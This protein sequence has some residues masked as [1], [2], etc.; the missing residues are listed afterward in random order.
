[1]ERIDAD[2]SLFDVALEN[3]ERERQLLG[4]LSGASEEWEQILK[5]PWREIRAILLA[6]SDEGQRLRSSHPF[7]GIV[8]EDERREIIARHPPPP[9]LKPISRE[10]PDPELIGR[11]LEEGA[12]RGS[13]DIR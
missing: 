11:V 10:D 6:D 1:M 8:T 13:K 2:P 12:S 9:P 5:R 7:V 3:L 4:S